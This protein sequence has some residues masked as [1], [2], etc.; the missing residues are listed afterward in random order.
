[1]PEGPEVAT[2]TDYLDKICTNCKLNSKCPLTPDPKSK[3]SKSL[4]GQELLDSILEIDDVELIIDEV[5]CKGKQIFFVV[6]CATS[7]HPTQTLYFNSH[8]GMTGQWRTKPKAHTRLTLHLESSKGPFDLYFD[9][10]RPF[11]SFSILN[12]K[13]FKH[14]IASKLGPDL[15]SDEVYLAQ[16]VKV[17][18]RPRL[19]KKQIC[20]FL[21]TQQYFCGIGNYLKSEVMYD[22]QVRPDRELGTLTNDEI[23]KLFKNSVRKIRKSYRDGGLTIRNY[24][25]PDGRTGQFKTK[26]YGKT[27]DPKGR[28]VTKS[29]FKDKRTSHFVEGYQ[30]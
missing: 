2:I 22:A 10:I 20:D 25:R 7:Q 12:E 28:P 5:W 11:G 24:Y 18:T 4:S 3:F 6:S 14:K 23:E 15:L 27:H 17:I 29:E 1:M 30:R 21:M 19:K 13:S 9:D 26:V 8:L 16:W